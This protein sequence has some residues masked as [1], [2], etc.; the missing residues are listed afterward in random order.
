MARKIRK[1]KNAGW[2]NEN[3]SE[4]SLNL[5]KNIDVNY[6]PFLDD[7]KKLLGKHRQSKEFIDTTPPSNEIERHINLIHRRI[8]DLLNDIKLL[9]QEVQAEVQTF[10]LEPKAALADHLQKYKIGLML[11]SSKIRKSDKKMSAGRRRNLTEQK[12]I[13]DTYNLI[14]KHK[15]KRILVDNKHDFIIQLLTLNGVT[16]PQ[17]IESTKAIVKKIKKLNKP[18]T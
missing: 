1:Q 9:P 7:F 5:L 6:Q 3:V 15:T 18:C 4:Q 12:L 14:D 10:T 11:A 17:S 13:H 16:V 2:V 8:D